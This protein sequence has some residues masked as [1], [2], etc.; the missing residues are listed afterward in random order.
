MPE[1]EFELHFYLSGKIKGTTDRAI[2]AIEVLALD[3]RAI[4][5]ERKQ[6]V[7]SLIFGND[8]KPDELKLLD[9]DL[10]GILLTD[11]QQPNQDDK[12]PPFSPVLV[13]I[14]GLLLTNH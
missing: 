2:Q 14:I 6:L 1:C 8:M 11:L 9:N 10:L 4:R 3:T 5:E 7:D 13:N 12:L